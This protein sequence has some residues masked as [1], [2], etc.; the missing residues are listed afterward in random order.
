MTEWLAKF[1]IREMTTDFEGDALYI[2]GYGG[3]LD[4]RYLKCELQWYESPRRLGEE[5]AFS[6]LEY[7]E[8]W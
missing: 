2:G 4:F 7:S 5:S 8:A 6:P 3:I 1:R